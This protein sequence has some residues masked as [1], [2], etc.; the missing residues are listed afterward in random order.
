MFHRPAVKINQ[1][2]RLITISTDS[3][4][5]EYIQ[6][7]GNNSWELDALNPSQ[8]TELVETEL[9]TSLIDLDAW[10]ATEEQEQKDQDKILQLVKTLG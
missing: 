5:K 4:A 9:Q 6:R 2:I 3:R 8:L 10:V 1:I 7:F